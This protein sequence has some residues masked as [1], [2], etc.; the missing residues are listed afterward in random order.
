MPYTGDCHIVS[1]AQDGQVRLAQL[2]LMGTCKNSKKLVQHKG[3]AHKVFNRFFFRNQ[4][5][6]LKFAHLTARLQFKF[7][8]CRF[9]TLTASMF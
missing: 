4:V 1:C 2:S 6:I 8:V 3:A 7:D 9:C 5:L